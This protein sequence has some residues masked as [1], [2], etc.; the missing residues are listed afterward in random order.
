MRR[1]MISVILPVYNG[2]RYLEQAVESILAQDYPNIEILIIDDGST[3]KTAI[4]AKKFPGVRYE[5][6]ENRGPSSARNRGASLAKGELL[7]F[8]DHDDFWVSHKLSSQV[9][10]M[11]QN[12]N[13][14]FVICQCCILPDPEFPP[15]MK[16]RKELTEHPQKTYIP[17]G[18]L[19]RKAILEQ[20]GG[21]DERYRTDED[22]DLMFRLRDAKIDYGYCE[23]LLFY[24]R[25]HQTN[26]SY[27]N[28]CGFSAERM[29]GSIRASI[30]RKNS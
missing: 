28:Q 17:S 16:L 11:G 19:I 3:D 13:I 21:F 12:E 30:K 2:E 26:L 20:I 29:L 18:L 10:A 6:Q 5:F 25:M 8:L 22:T 27:K 7:S 23:E 4:V 1:S 9:K 14:G 15:P 24:H